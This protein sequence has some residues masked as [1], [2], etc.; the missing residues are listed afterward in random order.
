M[1]FLF[2]G[3]SILMVFVSLSLGG[4]ESSLRRLCR[5]LDSGPLCDWCQGELDKR[6]LLNLHLDPLATAR[7]KWSERASTQCDDRQGALCWGRFLDVAVSSSVTVGEGILL[8][9]Q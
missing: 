1:T 9:V 5:M 6:K 3:S 8:F 2:Y 4:L 7:P